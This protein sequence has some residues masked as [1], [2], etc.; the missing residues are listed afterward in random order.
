MKINEMEL[1]SVVGGNVS[2]TSAF[3]SSVSKAIESILDLGRSLGSAVRRIT[4][5][6]ICPF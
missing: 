2:I 6:N 4:S 3:I 5:R 1:R